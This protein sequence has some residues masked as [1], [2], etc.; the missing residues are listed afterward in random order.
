MSAPRRVA[1]AMSGGVDSS[2][3][4]ALLLEQ[5]YHVRGLTARFW[6]EHESDR[7]IISARGVCDYLGIPHEVIDLRAEFYE[8]VVRQFLDEYAQGRTP[9]PCIVCNRELKFGLLLAQATARGELLATGHYARLVAG[10]AGWQL[11]AAID[12]SK[13]QSYFLYMLGQEQMA[14]LLFPLGDWRKADVVAWAHAR[15]L[16]TASRAESQDVCFLADGDYRR[17]IREHAPALLRPGL[18][19]DQQGCILGEHGGLA[20]YTVGQREGLGIAVGEPLYVLALDAARDDAQMVLDTDPKLLSPRG[21]A[22]RTLLYLFEAD[23]A[24]RLFRAA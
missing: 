24:V 11:R 8:A 10:P 15:G 13:D 18:I 23:E 17:F 4:A 22:L 16:P 5:G 21:Q 1:V 9:N 20:L 12:A 14:R 2:V 3:T 7:D 6:R 19:E